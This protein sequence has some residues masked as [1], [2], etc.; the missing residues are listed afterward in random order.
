MRKIKIL[1]LAASILIIPAVSFAAFLPL[2]P[3]NKAA[4]CNFGALLT[5]VNNIINY[6]LLLAVPIA[7]IMFA[8]AGFIMITAGGESAGAKTKA[9]SI[10]VN[11]VIG[12]IIALAAWLVVKLILSTLGFSPENP[13]F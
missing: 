5:L 9:K 13:L 2:V 12:F 8:Y 11:T 3:C 7:A 4:D 1:L 10:I 6:M